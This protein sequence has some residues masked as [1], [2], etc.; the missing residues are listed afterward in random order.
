MF[1]GNHRKVQNFFCPNR[2][3]SW[4]IKMIKFNKDDNEGVVKLIDSA[5]FMV[6]SLSNLVNN[7]AEGIQKF[8]CK[9]CYCFLEC[10][11]IKDNLIK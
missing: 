9:D 6:T 11:S 5:R 7:L 4:L 1:W 8:K 10:E 2:K 3:K